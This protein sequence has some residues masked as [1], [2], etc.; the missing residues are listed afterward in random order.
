MNEL[1]TLFAAAAALAGILTSIC[2]WSPRRASAKIAAILTATAFLPAVYVGFLHLLS[3]PKPVELEWWHARAAEATVLASSMQE[4]EGI[5]LWLQLEQASE[6]RAY[7]LP[8]NR[9]LAEQL[10]A[11]RREAERNESALRMR[12]PFEA[13]EDELEPKFYA[14]PQPA[15]PAKPDEGGEG[16]AIYAPDDGRAA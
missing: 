12:L 6:P 7:V 4:D 16:P 14:A 1:T 5:Y 3:M 13:S 11:A 10:Q 2:I 9:A 15:P 8:W